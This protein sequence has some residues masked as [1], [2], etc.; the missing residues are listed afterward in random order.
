MIERMEYLE[1]LK[2]FI[3]KRIKIFIKNKRPLFKIF[4]NI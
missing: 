1:Q 2:R 4:N 3:K